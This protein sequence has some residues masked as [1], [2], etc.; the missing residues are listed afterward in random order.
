MSTV[1]K[2]KKGSPPPSIRV[3]FVDNGD[4]RK[5]IE[6]DA[7]K[8]GVSISIMANMYIKAG[9]PLVVKTLDSMNKK[10]KSMS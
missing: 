5:T 3:Y 4:L 6:T 9:R 1:Q 7:K 10:A 2:K 8:F